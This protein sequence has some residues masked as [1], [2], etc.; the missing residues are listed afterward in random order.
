MRIL[1]YILFIICGAGFGWGCLRLGWNLLWFDHATGNSAWRTGGEVPGM[2][3]GALLFAVL[4][5]RRI[6]K[7]WSCGLPILPG[8]LLL[9]VFPREPA[10]WMI[11]LM[12]VGWSFF[13]AGVAMPP[14]RKLFVLSWKSRMRILLP[15]A[16]AL[17]AGAA[18]VGVW[19]QLKAFH[20]YYF[21]YLDWGEYAEFYLRGDGILSG[22]GH[23]NILP[24]LLLRP[25]IRAFPRPETLFAVNAV[26]IASGILCAGKLARNVGLPQKTAVFMAFCAA[27]LPAF[28]NQYLCTFYGYHPVVF[29]IPLLLGFFCCRSSGNRFGAFLCF[30]FSLLIQETA[31]FFWCGWALWLLS[32]RQWK[33]GMILLA[34]SLGC[35]VLMAYWAGGGSAAGYAQAGR[36]AVPGASPAEMSET[37]CRMLLKVQNL[38]FCA[39]LLLPLGIAAFA[40]PGILFGAL[41]ILAGVLLQ[42]YDSGK[43]P[44]SQ[45]AVELSILLLGAGIIH[46]GRLYRGE[47]SRILAFLGYGLPRRDAPRRQY[48]GIL[49]SLMFLVPSTHFLLGQ[50][51]FFGPRAFFGPE[52]AGI[53]PVGRMPDGAPVTRF[54]QKAI[55]PSADLLASG[56]LRSRF[57][58]RNVTKPAYAE[59]KPGD[60]IAVDLDDIFPS[61]SLR[62]KLWKDPRIQ[63]YTTVNWRGLR[64]VLYRISSSGT[65]E[66]RL[67]FLRYCPPAVFEQSGRPLAGGDSYFDFRL[68]PNR[69]LGV[70]V[71]RTPERDADLLLKIN[72]TRHLALPFANGFL[73]ANAAPPGLLFLSPQ[74]SEDISVV[75]RYR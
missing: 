29:L 74:E 64:F 52:R 58:F 33:R 37:F 50:T 23:C 6:E 36:Y 39:A 9:A 19:M 3:A 14:V 34:G 25:L 8:W 54:L 18:A 68:L 28:S 2:F 17:F 46:C 12:C 20:S 42:N 13:R 45:Y 70:Y 5:A 41:P 26:L 31:A 59:G 16:V 27:L 57:L 71:K 44:A 65:S 32:R 21:N 60:V 10:A 61:D 75:V 62:L 47:S 40:F 35:F 66:K 55:P 43:N 72:G 63:P 38:R 7:V 53:R 69:C 49:L 73:P 24:N 30:L 67:P 56:R 1:K 48:R 11:W 15:V 51:V 4:S 22:L